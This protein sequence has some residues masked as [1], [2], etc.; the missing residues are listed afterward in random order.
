MLNNFSSLITPVHF[1]QTAKISK[2]IIAFGIRL[3]RHVARVIEVKGKGKATLDR[4]LR[5]QEVE[6]PRISRK[7][8]HEGSKVVRHR[9]P[10]PSGD[11]P[12]LIAVKRPS[13]HHVHSE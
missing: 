2:C 13:R 5:L 7:S 10:L 8:A 9:P 11:T 1:Y 12:V 6:T 4:P 3:A